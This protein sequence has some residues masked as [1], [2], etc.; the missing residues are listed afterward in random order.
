M[1]LKE[2]TEGK[3]KLLVPAECLEKPSQGAVFFNPA[4]EKNRSISI[5]IAEYYFR[6]DGKEKPKILDLLSGVGARAVRYANEL[7]N[8]EVW[9]NDVQP[10]A[11]RLVE[12]NAELN[13][14]KIRTSNEEANKFLV[15]NKR[16]KFDL[17]DIDPFGS[18][19]RFLANAVT[20]LN[21]NGSLLAVTATDTGTLSGVY[22]TA[23]AR[24]YALKATRTSFLHELGL[25][26]LLYVIMREAGKHDYFTRPVFAYS[27][28]HY[29]RAFV[30]IKGGR[31]TAN[32]KL[33]EIGFVKYCPACERREL[34]PINSDVSTGCECGKKAVILGPTWIGRL[35][36]FN[37]LTE[38]DYSITTPYYDLPSL[39]KKY[40][41]KVRKREEI[42][43]TL[44]E[45]GFKATR[46]HFTGQGIRTN[47]P[48]EEVVKAVFA[49]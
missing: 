45:K 6:K 44:K 38:E 31:K 25:R 5:T 13:N 22:F 43:K 42:L 20:A 39:A 16:E 27:H 36:E 10:S 11:V 23:C 15:D 24:R 34:I 1:E 33:K 49:D 9:A 21:P 47:A 14:V 17:V 40:K 41:K 3:T 26:N 29:Y 28:I 35:G 48:Y 19:I 37:P 30:E 2:I 46:T 12:K 8:V 7:E 32:R 4:M 18:P